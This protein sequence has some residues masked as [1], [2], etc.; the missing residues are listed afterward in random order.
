M[1]NKRD[2]LFWHIEY[3]NFWYYILKNKCSFS[4]KYQNLTFLHYPA[5]SSHIKFL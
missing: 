2:I 4:N 5:D 3:T 1:E